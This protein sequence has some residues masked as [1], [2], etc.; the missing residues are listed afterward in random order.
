MSTDFTKRLPFP[1][2]AL[3]VLLLLTGGLA[4]GSPADAAP[5]ESS[6]A[7]TP[8]AL[9]AV[10]KE[11]E[12]LGGCPLR[13]T[14][15]Q[16]DIAGFIARVTLTQE[17]VNPFPKPI[18]AI[19][20]FP[21]SDR[22]AVDRMTM[23][24]GERV[25]K[26]VIKE[27]EEARRIYEAARQAGKIASLLDQERPNIF[28][29]SVANILPGETVHITIS[30]VEYL[31]YEEGEYEFSFPMVV[32]PRYIPGTPTEEPPVP[33]RPRRTPGLRPGPPQTDQV[34]DAD[35]ITP[36]IT[37][38]GTRAGHDIALAVRLDAGLPL[39][40]VLSVLHEVELS[41]PTPHSAE[42][43]L[44]EQRTIP[45]RDFVLKYGVA[46]GEI[47]DALITH[48]DAEGG[49]F[50][51]IMQP[52][53]QVDQRA[54][55]PREMI[56]VIDSSGSM[57]GF[58]IEKAKRAMAMSIEGMHPDDMFNLLTF[59]GGT[60]F[61][62]PGPV[63]NTPDNR[64]R[65]LAFLENLW[66]SGGTEMM[67][68]IQAALADQHDPERLRVVCFMTDGFVGN[69]MAIVDAVRT[70][71]GDA[72]VFSFGIG[73]SVNRFL[74]ENMAR[75]G[76][77]AS[78]VITLESD[79][80][81]AAERFY[82]RI[83]QP[84]LTDISLDFGGLPITDVYP[85]PGEMPDLFSAQPLVITGRYSGAAS[86][87]VTVRGVTAAGPFERRIEVNLPARQDENDVLAPL[88]ARERIEWLMAQ[89]WLGMQRG[90]PDGD[91][92][93]EITH[94]GIK[95]GLV[96]QY[97]SFVAVEE[98]VVTDGGVTQTVLVPV[99][100]ADGVSYEGVFGEIGRD[101]MH[102]TMAGAPSMALG[103]RGANAAQALE[104]APPPPPMSPPPA[105]M[106]PESKPEPVVRD[107]DRSPASG[108]PKVSP[109]LWGIERR[110]AQGDG[111][112]DGLKMRDGKVEVF[113]RMRELDEES[114]RLLREAGVEIVSQVHSSRTVLAWVKVGDIEKIAALDC[115]RRI[116]PPTY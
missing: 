114:L 13:H 6:V 94:L 4:G 108:H 77:G 66:G 110:A 14:D 44:K 52:P 35:R 58:P 54:V 92:K 55:T 9:E 63:P 18:E 87:I 31:K 89:D 47:A 96:T 106:R 50:T 103:A 102:K 20:T 32:G 43:R 12:P 73:N 7:A 41:R 48:T 84:L 93:G 61:C 97:T 76:R 60:Q 82:R 45:N 17:F 74:I 62:F 38:K 72:R 88:W 21:M 51:L 29:Q 15:V 5:Q 26:G 19:Y 65:A 80:E 11:G 30:Y 98:K 1:W 39:H 49:Y 37:P 56:F 42:L 67:A 2:R 16:V 83:H 33:V 34:P 91:V 57:R 101:G 28:T 104:M 100:M 25:I 78:E 113:V 112:E 69:D 10:D 81:I 64:R 3:C 115:V 116:E 107:E 53:A 95:Y 27:R 111:T 8:G 71:S 23:T 79:G 109:R 99:E 40:E 46:G 85:D 86:G 36:P 59:S 75:A 68:A 24:I 22:A 105:E 70:H 90:R